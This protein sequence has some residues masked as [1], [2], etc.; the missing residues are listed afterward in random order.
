LIICGSGLKLT[1]HYETRLL[2]YILATSSEIQDDLRSRE[3]S[4][5]IHPDR[6][7]QVEENQYITDLD[8]NGLEEARYSHVVKNTKQYIKKSQKERKV[9]RKQAD[10][11]SQTRSGKVIFKPLTAGQRKYLQCLS[12][13]TIA[14]YLTDR[15]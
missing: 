2:G 9:F 13:D 1:N 11:L 3:V 5:N 6:R 15:K 8:L 14:A 4:S 10:S 12:K 7:A